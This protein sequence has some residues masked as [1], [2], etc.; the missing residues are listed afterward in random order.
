MKFK[1]VPKRTPT[2]NYHVDV[3]LTSIIRTLDEYESEYGLDMN[4]DF[5]R[6]HVWRVDQQ[7]AFIEYILQGGKT[8]DILF[9][10]PNWNSQK[11][12]KMVLVDGLQRINAIIA[13]LKNYIPAFGHFYL[14]YE[15]RLPATMTVSFR[16]NDLKTRAQVLQW[17]IELN[18][19]GTPHSTLEIERVEEL[20]ED[21]LAATK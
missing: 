1:D 2:G 3:P 9:N 5:Q 20:L 11:A 6:G 18:S 16:V 19:G 8:S 4:P 15:D 7:V 10:E 13:F 21:E 17:Y 12:G 14:D